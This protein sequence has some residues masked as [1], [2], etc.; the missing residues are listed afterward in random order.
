MEYLSNAIS[1]GMIPR[2]LLS[3]V[4][5]TLSDQPDGTRITSVV[6]HA[7]TAAVLGVALNKATVRLSKGDALYVA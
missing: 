3:Q 1:L 6:G 5:F 4:C 2:H 7:D